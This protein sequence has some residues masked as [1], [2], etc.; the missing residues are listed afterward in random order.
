MEDDFLNLTAQKILRHKNNWKDNPNRYTSLI[1][2]IAAC[3]KPEQREELNKQLYEF[4]ANNQ[5]IRPETAESI[6]Y[7][8][9][10]NPDFRRQKF[11]FRVRQKSQSGS[12]DRLKD[13][14]FN[15]QKANRELRNIAFFC[16]FC[17]R[18][19]AKERGLNFE[20]DKHTIPDIQSGIT[21]HI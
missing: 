11:I 5:G 15:E 2:D 17:F 18:E 16:L 3:L 14:E 1:F 20:D 13:H 9:W 12:F 7:Q 10:V 8:K 19:L 6:I 21:T 4:S